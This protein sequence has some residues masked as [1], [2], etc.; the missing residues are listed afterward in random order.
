MEDFL[1]VIS[2]VWTILCIILFFKIWGATNNI[3]E[4][5]KIICGEDLNKSPRYL[6][7]CEKGDECYKALN[8]QLFR[9]LYE[10]AHKEYRAETFNNDIKKPILERY[11]TAYKQ[12]GREIPEGIKNLT[13]DDLWN[14]YLM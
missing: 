1:L 11:E 3:S 9:H 10:A 4:I 13:W 5:K 8:S 6:H 14:L 2:I 7:A 12:I